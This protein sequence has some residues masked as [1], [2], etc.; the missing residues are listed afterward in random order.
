M[1]T[2]Q[3]N[4]IVLYNALLMVEG[5]AYGGLPLPDTGCPVPD[6]GYIYLVWND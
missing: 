6:V 1:Q 3:Q 2:P 4:M 5:V